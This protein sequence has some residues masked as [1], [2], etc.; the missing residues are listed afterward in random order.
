MAK[1]KKK[2]MDVTAE[3]TTVEQ[4]TAEE[5]VDSTEESTLSAAEYE[6]L[7]KE[8]DDKLNEVTDRYQRLM[9]EYDN[10]KKRTQKEKEAIY[11]DSVKDTVVELLPVIDNLLRAI[12]SFEDKDSSECKGVEMVLKQTEDIFTKIGVSE[13]KAVGEEFNPELHNAVMHVEDDTVTEN[14]VVEEFQKGYI[15]KDKVIRYS[16]VKVA[17]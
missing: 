17:N 10:F 5:T 1:N 8:K 9:A 6:K 3:E 11:V 13:I 4:E 12:D 2:D 14:T 7:L 16:M 15:Y